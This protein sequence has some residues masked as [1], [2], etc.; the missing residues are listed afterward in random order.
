[1]N[2]IDLGRVFC[3][4]VRGVSPDDPLLRQDLA[5]CAAAGVGGVILFDI[6]VPAWNE[7]VSRGDDHRAAAAACPR[8]IESPEQLRRLTTFIKSQ[9]GEH[10]MICVD[11]EGGPTSRLG[12]SHSFDPGPD[13]HHFAAMDIERRRAEANR[14]AA[15]LAAAG[16]GVNLAPCVDLSIEPGSS[17][18]AGQGRSFGA[19]P[20]IVVENARIVLE[21]HAAHGVGACLKHF[22]GHGSVTGDSHHGAVDITK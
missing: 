2:R 5:A 12:A 17:I 10:T 18:I 20:E 14:Q 9:L 1:M 22:P 16:I 3:V 15:Q 4:G 8:N 11:Q 21:A 13:A 7:R 19:V 6:D